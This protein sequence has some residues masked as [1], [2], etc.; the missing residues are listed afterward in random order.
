MADIFVYGD[1][2]MVDAEHDDVFAYT[3]SFNGETVLVVCN[4][5]ESV[6]DWTLPAG[7]R[8]PRGEEI[9]I[10]TYKD[11]TSKPESVVLRPFEAF[12]CKQSRLVRRLYVQR[13]HI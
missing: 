12:A 10:S 8:N 13:L 2:E 5:R 6:V 3:R 1:F 4:F 7:V 9:L 11:V